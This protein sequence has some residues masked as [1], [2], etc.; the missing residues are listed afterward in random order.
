M[1]EELVFIGMYPKVG[2][3]TMD[4][5][6]PTDLRFLQAVDPENDP[7]CIENENL[8]RRKALQAE[9]QTGYE[10][11]LKDIKTRVRWMEGQDMRETIQDK[12]N[13]SIQHSAFPSKGRRFR[14]TPGLLKT[15]IPKRESILASQMKEGPHRS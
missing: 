7:L 5:F 1:H 6:S 15:E 9:Y 4:A 13:R 10:T 2:T 14:S 11:A 3:A 12:V 8:K